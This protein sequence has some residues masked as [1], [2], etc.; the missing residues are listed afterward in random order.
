MLPYNLLPTF[1]MLVAHLFRGIS[2][3]NVRTTIQIN[4]TRNFFE[5]IIHT[6]R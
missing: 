6:S 4:R 5:E 3:L 2:G 1:D